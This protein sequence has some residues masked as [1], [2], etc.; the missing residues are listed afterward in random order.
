[1][2]YILNTPYIIKIITALFLILIVNRKSGNLIAAIISGTLLLALWCGHGLAS[3]LSISWVRISSWGNIFLVIAIFQVIWLSSMM[4]KSG[5]MKDLVAIVKKSISRR[6]GLAVLPAL[7]G[8]LPMPGGALFSAPMVEEMD[9]GKELNPLLKTKINYWFRHIWEYWWPLYP[10]VLLAIDMTKLPVWQFISLQLPLSLFAIA[11]GIF[12]LLRKV[13]VDLKISGKKDN[14]QNIKV[15]IELIMPILMVIIVYIF[16]SIVFPGLSKKSQ[17]IPVILG[18]CFSLGTL[19]IQRPLSA[20]VLKDI[21]LSKNTLKLVVIVIFI[22]IYGAFIESPLPDGTFL[23]SAVRDELAMWHIPVL[24]IIMLIPFISGLSTGLAVGF[25]GASFPI[26]INL[27]GPNPPLADL[28]SYTVLAYGFGFTGMMLSPVHVCHL[29]TIEYFKTNL[30]E[31]MLRIIKPS[32]FVIGGSIFM[33]IA[34][35]IIAS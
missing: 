27:L 29:V 6:A 19:Q 21:I 9:D 25:V 11:G 26:V 12:F 35:H 24:V 3:M 4:D 23:M 30:N 14:Y 8:W 31:S 32:L 22:R 16:V 33:S 20:G 34:A 10:G 7:I 15:F 18:L 5:V 13:P 17:Y 2:D 28:L 1:M